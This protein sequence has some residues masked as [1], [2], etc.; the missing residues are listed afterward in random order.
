VGGQESGIGAMP[1]VGFRGKAPGSV[2][3][4]KPP[5]KLTTLCENRPMLFMVALCNRADHYIFIL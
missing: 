5:K 2:W 1:P 3:E 4:V